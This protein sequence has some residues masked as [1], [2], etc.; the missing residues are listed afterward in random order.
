MRYEITD[1]A[2]R[3]LAIEWAGDAAAAIAAAA[4]RLNISRDRLRARLPRGD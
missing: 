2:G 4:H 3:V 1:P